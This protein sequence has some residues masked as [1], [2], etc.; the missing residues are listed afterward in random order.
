MHDTATTAES[1]TRQL[2]PGTVALYDGGP[3][4]SVFV[5][6]TYKAGRLSLIGVTGP[7]SNGNATGGCGQMV[8]DLRDPSFKPAPGW[9]RELAH[10]LADVW[11]RWHLNDMRAGC[12]HQRAAGWA[13]RPIDPEKPT[14]TYGRHFDGQQQDS[15]NLL[16]WIR[17]DEHPDGL[18]TRPCPECGYRYGS[19]WQFEPV[20][21][22][23]LDW[24]RALPAADRPSPWGPPRA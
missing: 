19:A 11:D 2:R 22:D 18:L 9:T 3:R 1:W 12:E 13:E 7:R 20:P 16:G 14:N 4:A 15:W 23:V 24:L 21:A 6:V 10:Q 8:G 5:D 17:P